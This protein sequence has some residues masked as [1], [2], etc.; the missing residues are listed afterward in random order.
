[1]GLIGFLRNKTRTP[2]KRLKKGEEEEQAKETK[3]PTVLP[4]PETT[5]NAEG[6]NS[7]ELESSHFET[8]AVVTENPSVAI[9][10]KENES[11]GKDDT[12]DDDEGGGK[13]PSDLD[14]TE[15]HSFEIV[16]IQKSEAPPLTPLE[17]NGSKDESENNEA[18]ILEKFKAKSP[19]RR[20]STVAERAAWLQNSAFKQ[21]DKKTEEQFS[22]GS[23]EKAKAK[24]MFWEG[25]RFQKETSSAPDPPSVR[26]KMDVQAKKKWLETFAFTP[27]GGGNMATEESPPE[28]RKHTIGLLPASPVNSGSFDKDGKEQVKTRTAM[29]LLKALDSY[30]K[31]SLHT[32]LFLDKEDDPYEWAYE[33]WFNKGLLPWRSSSFADDDTT[34]HESVRDLVISPSKSW[35]SNKESSPTR[36][37]NELKQAFIGSNT[38]PILSSD[39]KGTGEMATRS[40]MED[41]SESQQSLIDGVPTLTQSDSL[42]SEVTGKAEPESD[43]LSL[44]DMAT[45]IVDSQDEL[46][47]KAMTDFQNKASASSETRMVSVD[48]MKID[49]S[50]TNPTLLDEMRENKKQWSLSSEE[51]SPSKCVGRNPSD[52]VK[53][54]GPADS[55]VDSYPVSC[56]R[57]LITLNPS[58]NVSHSRSHDASS[59]AK[60]N[61]E[62]GVDPSKQ[63]QDAPMTA[64]EEEEAA[65]ASVESNISHADHGD[66]LS[67]GFG[68]L[69][70]PPLPVGPEADLVASDSSVQSE[71]SQHDAEN[72]DI[73]T[74]G[75]FGD[76]EDEELQELFDLQQ[77]IL[78]KLRKE[79]DDP[80]ISEENEAGVILPNQLGEATE[81]HQDTEDKLEETC[82]S[83]DSSEK[84]QRYGKQ[85]FGS[86]YTSDSMDF[87]SVDGD[88]GVHL[89][90]SVM[91]HASSITVEEVST[92]D[93][94]L[95]ADSF[96]G[97]TC[98]S[99][100][101]AAASFELVDE[102]RFQSEM[103][104]SNKSREHVFSWEEHQF[105]D[106]LVEIIDQAPVQ[107]SRRV[108]T[109]EN[110][111]NQRGI[112]RARG[113]R[114]PSADH[115]PAQ[116]SRKVSVEG[117]GL[118]QVYETMSEYLLDLERSDFKMSRSSDHAPAQP[119]R[120]I[121]V[122]GQDLIPM[123][124]TNVMHK[125]DTAPI[126]P[127]RVASVD[128][129]SPQYTPDSLR[130]AR[131]RKI[132]T[133]IRGQYVVWLVRSRT[134]AF[135]K[136]AE[137]PILSIFSSGTSEE[138]NT[139]AAQE[140]A[141]PFVL[142][143]LSV[144]P[145]LADK[146]RPRLQRPKPTLSP[147]ERTRAKFLEFPM[148]AERRGQQEADDDLEK[149]FGVL[150]KRLRDYISPSRRKMVSDALQ[151]FEAAKE[152]KTMYMRRAFT[153]RKKE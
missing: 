102:L 145:R 56:E 124:G 52:D 81:H 43:S 128:D 129:F 63:K 140:E 150:K 117:S 5:E 75:E 8:E 57:G 98:D 103:N 148:D 36:P 11:T 86:Q 69:K 90:P 60:V 64:R 94:V 138:S 70:P 32:D 139:V 153:I 120:K 95:L 7:T 23:R 111:V 73:E 16:E 62:L 55:S 37:V 144:P 126:T 51:K 89:E 149:S 143:F 100:K 58:D 25:K 112:L 76:D 134:T 80:P 61:D 114:R 6:T 110:F 125:H 26:N 59:P 42:L 82:A 44:K 46:S 48:G 122:E 72:K 123:P 18:S 83:I 133:A 53:S 1:M 47:T 13:D 91:T 71:E 12:D 87:L 107:P 35:A 109:E 135:R 113:G 101:D 152:Q 39:S 104:A 65:S 74:F 146:F 96:D 41:V 14:S 40:M 137:V 118:G 79:S 130:R 141:V 151:R 22:P 15:D 67:N 97:K 33:V 106:S 92:T 17:T 85:Y 115:A 31:Q 19:P 84:L 2:K 38:T 77:R 28:K 99:S 66:D 127:V 131:A 45:Q 132:A 27:S 30:G 78:Q 4:E 116:P 3:G 68:D 49:A 20:G 21:D 121:S 54:S 34:I 119:M 29:D 9:P 147:T 50:Q 93:A 24:K 136:S 105:D 142:P 10:N 88:S 108:S